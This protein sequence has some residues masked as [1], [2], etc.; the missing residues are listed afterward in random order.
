M[1]SSEIYLRRM[2]AI[3]EVKSVVYLFIFLEK[4][5]Y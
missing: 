5:L 4:Y 1:E 2:L 3:L